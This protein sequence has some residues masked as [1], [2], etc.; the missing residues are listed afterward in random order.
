MPKVIVSFDGA[1]IAEHTLLQE[2]TTLGR[3]PFNDIVIDNLA[4]SGQHLV[5][6][7]TPGEVF[8]EDLNSTN[9]TYVNGKVAR[10]QAL[11]DGDLL[12]V[13]K[14]KIKFV[15]DAVGGVSEPPVKAKPPSNAAN[16]AA[17]GAT[18]GQL[19]GSIK[20]L[21]GAAAGREVPLVKA[22]TTFG[23]PGVAVAA[24]TRGDQAF[25]VRHVE[26]GGN[27]MLNGEPLGSEPRTLRNGDQIE[28]AGTRMEFIQR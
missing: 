28:L 7:M 25:S 15:N 12:E 26:G 19:T 14:Y 18:G 4:V 8:V 3:R 23:K 17:A 2:R 21:S 11:K 13:G 9:G 20:V 24:I 1:V 27:P 22:V 10:K 16:N 5:F 6:L